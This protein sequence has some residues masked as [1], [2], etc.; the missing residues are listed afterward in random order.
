MD[1]IKALS[2]RDDAPEKASRP[3]D[4][5]RDGMVLSE[6]SGVIILEEM[7]RAIKRNARIY[8]EVLGYGL[9]GDA[10]HIYSSDPKGNGQA[11][12]MKMALDDAGLEPSQIDNISAHGTSTQVADISETYA[13]KQ[14]FGERAK[15]LPVS[16]TKSMLGHLWGAAG[17][18]EAIAGILTI[19]HGTIPPTI[20]YE[21]PDPA[22]D[23]DYVPNATRKTKVNTVLTNT[24]GFGGANASLILGRF[25]S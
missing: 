6:G 9:S 7:E 5:D 19:N 22:C 11:I 3:F 10:Y 17:V 20:N 18:A 13:I 16:A 12:S 2:A 23:L 1:A 4:K 25:I 8:A 14:V 24:F 15:K 21:T